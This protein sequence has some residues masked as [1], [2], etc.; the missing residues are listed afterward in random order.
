MTRKTT[1]AYLSV[2]RYIEQNLF[3]LKPKEFMTDYEDGMR[4]AIRKH[5]PKAEIRGCWFHLKRAV[6]R[7]C[8]A[9]GM[10]RILGKNANARKI[11]R[12]LANIPLLPSTQIVDGFTSVTKFAADKKLDKTFAGV[13]K[14]FDG[15]WLKQQVTTIV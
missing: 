14:Y 6:N 12:M 2:F 1:E 9:K 8:R 5:W 4:A 15:Y 3:E 11:K 10:K 7:R 13:F